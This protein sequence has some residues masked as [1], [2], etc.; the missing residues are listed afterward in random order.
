MPGLYHNRNPELFMTK[1]PDK[2]QLILVLRLW[3]SDI[4]IKDS[5]LS[6]WMGEVQYYIPQKK[7]LRLPSRQQKVEE[8]QNT[9][10]ALMPYLENFQWQIITVPPHQQPAAIQHLHWDGKVLLI[11][12]KDP[13]S[14]PPVPLPLKK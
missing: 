10:E 7:L 6:L 9:T 3:Q 11:K 5:N 1:S 2:N 12:D 4:L 14:A 8:L 13:V